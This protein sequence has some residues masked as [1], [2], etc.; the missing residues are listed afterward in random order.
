MLLTQLLE[1]FQSL[2]LLPTSKLGLSGA[3]SQVGVFVSV[4][5]PSGSLQELSCEAESSSHCLNPQRFF[6]SEV[7]RLYFPVLEYWVAWSVLLP[8]C[9]S[10]LICM[11]LW[12]CPLHQPLPG[13]EFSP[14]WLP[15]LLVW[16]NVSSLSPWLLDF[17]T[18]RF[19][20]SFGYF[21]F[22]NLLLSFFRLC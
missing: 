14:P 16:M 11:Q 19:S 8:S 3:D 17:H 1:G 10:Q 20:G 7:L 18:V 15:I 22:L 12:D 4:L 9:P 21:L 5:G 6:H 13:H 2:P